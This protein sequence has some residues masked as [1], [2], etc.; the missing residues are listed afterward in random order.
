MV[1]AVLKSLRT[2]ENRGRVC[3]CCDYMQQ[4]KHDSISALL[5]PFRQTVSG[6]DRFRR[7]ADGRGMRADEDARRMAIEQA[8]RGSSS[9]P[10]L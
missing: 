1:D 4:S 5:L 2:T 3:L 7:D 6:A 9:I 8:A 10:L